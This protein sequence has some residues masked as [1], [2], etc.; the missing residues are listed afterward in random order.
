MYDRENPKLFDEADIGNQNLRAIFF[1]LQPFP[2]LLHHLLSLSELLIRFGRDAILC[3]F[4]HFIFYHRKETMAERR[5]R[6]E[7]VR[8]EKTRFPLH[9]L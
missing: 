5:K 9:F 3:P 4:V 7:K 2:P 8:G 6:E 1:F